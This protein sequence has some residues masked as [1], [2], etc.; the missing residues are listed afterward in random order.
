[1]PGVEAWGVSGISFR[2]TAHYAAK[3]RFGQKRSN[4][5][6]KPGRRLSLSALEGVN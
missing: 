2:L 1:M 6:L 3:T 4:Q 5:A